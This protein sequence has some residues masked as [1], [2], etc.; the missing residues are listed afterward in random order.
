MKRPT[1]QPMKLILIVFSLILGFEM[2]VLAADEP[3]TQALM[4]PQ[5]LELKNKAKKRLYPGGKDEEP[6]KVQAQLPSVTRKM[7]PATEAPVEESS[8]DTATD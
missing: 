5:E 2:T 6:L 1:K 7:A 8:P 3:A 4:T